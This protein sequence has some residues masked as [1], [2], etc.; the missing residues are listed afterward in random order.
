[1]DKKTKFFITLLVF[2]AGMAF[3]MYLGR[4]TTG[5]HI[6]QWYESLNK[7]PMTPHEY[8]FPLVW[9]IIYF[10]IALGGA[11]LFCKPPSAKRA[12]ALTFWGLQI[13]F[14][15]AWSFCFFTFK[16]PLIAAFDI[17]FLWVTSMLAIIT[18]FRVSRA[19]GW[20][21]IPNGIWVSFAVYLNIAIVVLN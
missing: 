17:V 10:L 21:L 4:L 9:W 19:A 16:N 18:A 20:Y 8:T 5:E 14:N 6:E 15:L 13:F 1:M 11:I 7:P 3:I 12:I 2:L